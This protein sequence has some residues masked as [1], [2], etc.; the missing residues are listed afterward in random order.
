MNFNE[1]QGDLI[2]ELLVNGI[3]SNRKKKLKKRTR[4]PS[5]VD[6]A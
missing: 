6:F 4:K 1:S 2:D 5:D 3:H